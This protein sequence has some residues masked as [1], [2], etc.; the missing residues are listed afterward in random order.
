MMLSEVN[1]TTFP[2]WEH[3]NQRPRSLSW[4]ALEGSKLVRL[5][6]LDETGISVNEPV[7]VVAGVV[8]DADKHYMIVAQYIRD[9]IAEYVPED[10]RYGYWGDGFTFHAKDLF[11]GSGKVFDKQ[12]YPLERSHEV[13]KKLLG[14]PVL[15]Q[16]PVVCGHLLKR[17]VAG[18]SKQDLRHEPSKN[19]A[20]AFSLCALAAERYMKGV[21]DPLEIA[22]L[23][24]EDNNETRRMVKEMHLLLRGARQHSD[25]GDAL[26]SILL[27]IASDCLP[28]RRIVDTVSFAEKIDSFLLQIADACALVIRYY[29]EGRSNAGEF[30][31]ALTHGD[32]SV[33]G[34]RDNPAGF[35]IVTFE[36]VR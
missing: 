23:V 9:L 6:Y 4:A 16:L 11:H 35:R 24:A 12:K 5:V 18:M 1:A 20:F 3:T 30:I 25:G 34:A 26:L 19:Q 33:L 28:I 14:I 2:L 31:D 8:I 13:F 17:S 36:P 27:E 15:F 32:P 21:S 7:V 29:F 22:T 10:C